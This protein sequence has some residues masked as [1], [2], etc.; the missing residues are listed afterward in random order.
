MQN[1]HYTVNIQVLDEWHKLKLLTISL[2]WRCA[3]YSCYLMHV[4]VMGFATYVKSQYSYFLL[5]QSFS[6]ALQM[7]TFI[8][9]NAK[10][11][12]RRSSQG[13]TNITKAI[14]IFID[15]ITL[16]GCKNGLQITP[17]FYSEFIKYS[18]NNSFYYL[19]EAM[20][21]S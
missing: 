12:L 4:V 15:L 3:C 8:K 7:L 19:I 18:P 17:N 11:F 2:S 21:R 9:S 5:L 13:N 20:Q 6:N 16:I 1:K 10:V 14:L